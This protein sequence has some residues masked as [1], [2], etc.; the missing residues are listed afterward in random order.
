MGKTKILDRLSNAEAMVI[1]FIAEHSLSFSTSNDL[2]DLDRELA[3]D[4]AVLQKLRTTAS[5]KLIFGLNPTLNAE[6]VSNSNLKIHS[7]SLNMDESTS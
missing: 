3:K 6:L 1:A 4:P 2:I 5:Y 7:F